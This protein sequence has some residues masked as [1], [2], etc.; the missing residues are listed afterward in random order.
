[1]FVH[2]STHR[3][4]CDVVVNPELVREEASLFLGNSIAR[5]IDCS[6]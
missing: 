6:K 3:C 5:S 1:M 4:V 2:E